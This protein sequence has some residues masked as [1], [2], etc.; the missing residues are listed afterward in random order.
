MQQ[1]EHP[2]FGIPPEQSTR[3][4]HA[5]GFTT[6]TE[7]PNPQPIG[8]QLP[9]LQAFNPSSSANPSRQLGQL[10]F[11]RS[12]PSS[13]SA[14]GTSLGTQFAN[15]N[16]SLPFGTRPSAQFANPNPSLPL[17]QQSGL[18]TSPSA[19]FGQ[20]S[21]FG[22][23]LSTQF[24]N[25]LPFNQ[26]SAF[27]T[28]PSTQSAFGTSPGTQV[29]QQ[30]TFGR[31][32]STQLANPLPFSQQSAFGTSPSTQFANPNPS[33]QQSAFGISS[34]TQVGQQSTFGRSL[35]TQLANPLPFSQQSAFGTSSGT[36]V[37]QQ[38]VFGRN[39]SSPFGR[40]LSTPFGQQ[41]TFGRNP[42]SPFDPLSQYANPES[43]NV[44][45]RFGQSQLNPSRA[46]PVYP[47]AETYVPPINNP[48]Q[49]SC[50]PSNMVNSL[51]ALLNASVVREDWQTLLVIGNTIRSWDNVDPELLEM[52]NISIAASN[53]RGFTTESVYSN[54]QAFAEQQPNSV[55]LVQEKLAARKKEYKREAEEAISRVQK[56]AKSI[57][58]KLV[59]QKESPDIQ[60]EFKDAFF[61][62]EANKK[63]VKS[64]RDTPSHV[65]NE[66][67]KLNT[68]NQSQLEK[69]LLEEA[70]QPEPWKAF[71]I[72][73][74]LMGTL[75]T[76]FGSV[77]HFVRKYV[78]SNLVHIYVMTMLF[79]FLAVFICKAIGY[80]G[81]AGGLAA[82]ISGL[83][84]SYALAFLSLTFGTIFF[85]FLVA[86][87]MGSGAVY[88]LMTL[89]ASLQAQALSMY[90][91]FKACSRYLL[92]GGVLY[93][94]IGLAKT[95]IGLVCD[96]TINNFAATAVGLT[97][98]DASYNDFATSVLL[99]KVG[100]LFRELMSTMCHTF[101]AATGLNIRPG[102]AGLD[103]CTWYANIAGA[104]ADMLDIANTTGEVP[105]QVSNETQQI[106]A[107]EIYKTWE[108][109][110]WFGRFGFGPDKFDAFVSYI[111]SWFGNLGKSRFN[112]LGAYL[113]KLYDPSGTAV[114][115]RT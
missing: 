16:P 88:S 61:L 83:T 114:V 108:N 107:Q 3:F 58:Q 87:A 103:F 60:N 52:A 78:E 99:P 35:S 109:P 41:S 26:Q 96:L 40:S 80:G 112:N 24:A 21:T 9:S 1:F 102:I 66:A 101:F 67:I 75:V 98:C 86:F 65:L 5:T 23:S 62:N 115:T 10:A 43:R 106:L 13:Q 20:E 105:A 33:G 25:P 70:K 81:L 53:A 50:Q 63:E 92:L 82:A 74:R 77:E 36:Q 69:M 42:S 48:Q 46:I 32:L 57:L 47:V 19:Q 12:D 84:T 8:T 38:S 56:N 22:R 51:K 30:S 100:Y 15:P 6:R 79:K 31:S 89:P 90:V 34:G 2:R 29:G 27:G 111:E 44:P 59:D 18:R 45:S 4:R 91:L 110:S 85:G 54:L 14:F 76:M 37:G 39:P 95:I 97:F 55:K 7:V 11:G 104:I 113:R 28:S 17:G 49:Q 71:G 64:I 68:I 94:I 73:E 72:T 93:N